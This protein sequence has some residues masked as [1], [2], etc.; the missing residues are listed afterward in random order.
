MP[1]IDQLLAKNLGVHR[2][3]AVKLLT[4][5][6]VQ[7]RE[8]QALRDPKLKVQAPYC[9]TVQGQSLELR[10]QA[11]VLLHK[12]LG[13]V[14][15]L[16]DAQHPTAYALLHEA[17]LFALLRP[18]GR[19]DLNT[20]GLLLWTTQGELVHA[21]THPRRAVSRTYHVGLHR[22][23]SPPGEDFVLK[24]GHQPKIQALEKLASDHVHPALDRSQDPPV[25]ARITLQS[26]AYHEVRRIFAA[27]GSHVLSL[28]RVQ[29]GRWSLPEDLAPGAFV[30]VD[31]GLPG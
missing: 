12:P 16:K 27:L 13:C 20:S 11:S 4:R 19:L 25:F 31:L 6:A 21:L 17:P 15:A 14:T 24:D 1:R 9:V 2:R 8:G 23:F 3:E 18:V 22:P 30:S 28:C 5:G 29:H 7:D 26:G 10:E